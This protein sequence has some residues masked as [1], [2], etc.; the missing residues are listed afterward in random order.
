MQD[1][2]MYYTTSCTRSGTPGLYDYKEKDNETKALLEI[3]VAAGADADIPNFYG[4]TPMSDSVVKQMPLTTELLIDAGY[5]DECGPARIIQALLAAGADPLAE[6]LGC[7][8]SDGSPVYPGSP[9]CSDSSPAPCRRFSCCCHLPAAS[10]SA[11]AVY[12]YWHFHYP[13]PDRIGSYADHGDIDETGSDVYCEPRYYYY[14]DIDDNER[15][16][17]ARQLGSP[18]RRITSAIKKWSRTFPLMT[19]GLLCL[20]SQMMCVVQLKR[21]RRG[22]EACDATGSLPASR[23]DLWQMQRTVTAH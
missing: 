14:A 1:V 15:F 6:E 9:G 13:H 11:S 20:E 19:L 2:Y 12:D 18:L 4:S 21:Q 8:P 17:R 5:G 22:L 16:A 7:I 3:L 23:W 10:S